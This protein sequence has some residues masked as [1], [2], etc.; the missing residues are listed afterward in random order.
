[1]SSDALFNQNQIIGLRCNGLVSQSLC[2]LLPQRK[3]PMTCHLRASFFDFA[4]H[5]CFVL[6]SAGR[7][8][9]SVSHSGVGRGGGGVP[10]VGGA[11]TR[12][13]TTTCIPPGGDVCLGRV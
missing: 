10:K 7:A 11:Y 9:A 2:S 4:L 6:N 1:M 8:H 5:S 12:P 3:V 13:T